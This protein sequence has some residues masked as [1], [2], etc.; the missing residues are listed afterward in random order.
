MDDQNVNGN[1]KKNPSPLVYNKHE[2]KCNYEGVTTDDKES[3]G[4]NVM[5]R[6]FM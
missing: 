1:K 5:S 3:Q 4:K 2:N 6:S